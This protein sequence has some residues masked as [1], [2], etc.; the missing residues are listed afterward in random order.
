ML[1]RIQIDATCL[2]KNVIANVAKVTY[3]DMTLRGVMFLCGALDNKALVI[4]YGYVYINGQKKRII[5]LTY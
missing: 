5:M 3:K 2:D 1:R 4:W